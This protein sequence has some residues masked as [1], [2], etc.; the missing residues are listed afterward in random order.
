MR[1]YVYIGTKN[2]I[3]LCIKYNINRLIY[4][5]SAIVSLIPYM[6]RASFSIIVNQTESKALTPTVDSGFLIPGY[7]ATKL[8]AEKMVLDA[9]G[10]TLSNGEGIYILFINYL[11]I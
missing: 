3:N 6:G 9:Y 2:V 7:P 1:M 8:R 4:T 11:N 5:S 10:A